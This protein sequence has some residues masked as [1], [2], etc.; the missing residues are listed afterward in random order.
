LTK[1]PFCGEQIFDEITS[2]LPSRTSNPIT[3]N[4]QFHNERAILMNSTRS[5]LSAKAQA[6]LAEFF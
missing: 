6:R 2:E 5:N 1:N 3:N 4:A